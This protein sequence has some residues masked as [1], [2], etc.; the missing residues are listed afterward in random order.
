MVIVVLMTT[1]LLV[2]TG[3]MI[4]NIVSDM[5]K[6]TN[7]SHYIY[8][9]NLNPNRVTISKDKQAAILEIRKQ[10]KELG[11]TGNGDEVVFKIAELNNEIK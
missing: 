5:R 9:D 11:K 1:F 7:T 3:V 6:Q 10:I 8:I 2:N 4:G